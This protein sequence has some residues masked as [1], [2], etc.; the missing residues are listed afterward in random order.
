MGRPR[1][2]SPSEGLKGMKLKGKTAIITGAGS[3]MGRAMA[4][5]FAAEGATIVA[6]DWHQGDLDAVVAEVG[7]TG[8][9]IT[10]I[11]ANVAEQAEAEAMVDKA[12]D[13]YGRL[14]VLVNNAGV[15]DLFAP[16]GELDD[17]T[18]RRVMSVNLDGPMYACRRA[19]P[20]L[21]EQGGGV[22]LNT[23]SVAGLS[24]AAAG[25]AYT[26]SKHALI[27]LTLNTA[28]MYAG[29]GIRCNAIAA[30]GVETNIMQSIDATALNQSGL[31]VLTPYHKM[32]PRQLQPI[33]IANLALFLV[34]DEARFINGAIVPA[35]DGWLAA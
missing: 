2:A 30:G 22:I 35:D 16:V 27:G 8:A 4:N 13:A 6:A 15:M 26:A 29:R 32:M 19:V 24:G 5:L 17:E 14:D 28:W 20:K 10:G 34:S 23:A 9:T 7:K 21:Q 33:D 3:G 1:A 18:W 12:I 31:A 11:K 25:A